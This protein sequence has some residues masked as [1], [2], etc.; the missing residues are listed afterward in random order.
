MAVQI[1][2]ARLSRSKQTTASPSAAGTTFRKSSGEG[3]RPSSW[4]TVSPPLRDVPRPLRGCFR[5]CRTCLIVYDNRN[6]GASDAKPRQEFD[7]WQQ[8]RDY[9][10]AI[11][12]AET[13]HETDPER[14]GIWGTSYSGSHV[15]VVGA[16][17]RRVK[18]VV[19]QVPLVSGHDNVR[20]LVRPDHLAEIRKV[21]ADDR[22][23]RI[24]EAARYDPG[25]GRGS[26]GFL[27]AADAGLLDVVHG[28]RAS[29]S[30][31]VEE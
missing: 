8:V 7:P 19:S 26:G 13:L 17:D 29:A 24:A 9:R 22:R 12:Y 27:R 1:S 25:G 23:A 18:C 10:D 5:E 14:I 30:A 3:Y 15:L 4:R 16:I 2:C 31:V 28:D 6:F 11:T 20:R 21:F